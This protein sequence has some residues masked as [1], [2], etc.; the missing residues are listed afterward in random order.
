MSTLPLPPKAPDSRQER[1]KETAG[2]KQQRTEYL[3]VIKA[4]K[5]KEEILKNPVKK[6]SYS[7]S[8]MKPREDDAIKYADNLYSAYIKKYGEVE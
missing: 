7:Y 5:R 6:G 2:S 8:R 3:K 1:M 4:Q